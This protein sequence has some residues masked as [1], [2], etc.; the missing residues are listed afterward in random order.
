[1]ACLFLA[2]WASGPGLPAAITQSL[3]AA[4]FLVSLAV[5]IVTA[6]YGKWPEVPPGPGQG[7]KGH[8]EARIW[9]SEQGTGQLLKGLRI[10]ELHKGLSQR[11]PFRMNFLF[12]TTF[13]SAGSGTT[14]SISICLK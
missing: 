4:D 6:A 14:L 5:H 10:G 2:L 9:M 12:P 3:H 7:E 13:L 1:M 11:L 8:E